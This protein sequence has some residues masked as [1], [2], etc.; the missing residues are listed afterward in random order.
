MTRTIDD[1]VF[2]R[3]SAT[4]QPSWTQP[5]DCSAPDQFIWRDRLYVVR[6]VLGRWR[7][8]QAWWSAPVARPKVGS[9]A[10]LSAAA[11]REVWRVQAANARRE[12]GIF[13]LAA[14]PIVTGSVDGRVWRLLRVVD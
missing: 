12:E 7:E 8:R 6:G 9:V 13:D 1:P 3:V 5:A 10:E 4:G 14:D 2:V 11:D